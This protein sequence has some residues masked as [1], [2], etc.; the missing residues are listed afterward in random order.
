VR[1]SGQN[2]CWF[3]GARVPCRRDMVSAKSR[4]CGIP[5]CARR[6]N[7]DSAGFCGWAIFCPNHPRIFT[8]K[9]MKRPQFEYSWPYS[10]MV[11][12]ETTNSIRTRVNPCHIVYRITAS[13]LHPPHTCL[14]CQA[15]HGQRQGV[16]CRAANGGKSQR[17][18]YLL[19]T[20]FINNF[21]ES[22]GHSE[23]RK[24]AQGLAYLPVDDWKL[25][26]EG[27]PRF[28]D[29]RKACP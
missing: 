8:N 12:D 2:K 1:Y 21:C 18:K 11:Y 7:P 14:I 15:N 10:W 28:M 5:R 4:R 19:P 17:S 24:T 13:H 22:V 20:F 16:R 29:G 3:R 27:E 25:P 6:V 9:R 23:P 26:A